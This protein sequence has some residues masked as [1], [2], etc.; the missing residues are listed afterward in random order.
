MNINLIFSWVFDLGG[1][2]GTAKVNTVVQNK[3][4][5]SV[6]FPLWKNSNSV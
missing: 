5:S 4:L 1:L 2:T 6:S 3:D